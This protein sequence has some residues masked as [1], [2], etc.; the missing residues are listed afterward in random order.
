MKYQLLKR[1]AVAL[2]ITGA[3]ST[4]A[5]ATDPFSEAF[6]K[7]GQQLKDDLK[8]ETEAQLNQVK[9]DNEKYF[10]NTTKLIEENTNALKKKANISDVNDRFQATGEALEKVSEQIVD[11]ARSIEAVN[12]DV[13][14]NTQDIRVQKASIDAKAGK[15]YVAEALDKKAD[16]ATVD[17]E[18]AK[19]VSQEKLDQYHQSSVN[20]LAKHSDEIENIKQ[21]HNELADHVTSEINRVTDYVNNMSD[22]ID[23][24]T[25]EID[26]IKQAHNELADHVTSEINRVTD[27]VN[28]MSDDIDTNTA[29]IENI[30]QVHNELADHVTSEINR[31]TDYV[32]NMSDDVDANT[33]EIEKLKTTS[34]FLDA[35]KV[36]KNAKDIAENK[37]NIK[38]VAKTM[39]DGFEAISE[40]IKD[41]HRAIENV[42]KDVEK[43]TQDIRVQ[44][45]VIKTKASKEYVDGKLADKA[46]KAALANKAD[47][48]TV[49]NYHNSLVKAHESTQKAVGD[50]KTKIAANKAAVTKNEAAIKDNKE[51]VAKN[52]A[53][54]KANT[55]GIAQLKSAQQNVTA[56]K[57]KVDQNSARIDQLDNRVS[58]LDKEVKNGLASQAALSGLFQPYNVGKV[59]M[60]A[61]V[62]GY[63]SKTALAVGTGYRFN[64]NVAAKAGVAFSAN[65]G[66]ATYNAGVNFEW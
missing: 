27:Y 45:G 40:D 44:N 48:A 56:L 28:N 12:K 34:G 20:S 66:G 9:T 35:A 39:V 46:D 47:Q 41:N 1:T 16:K 32:N 29:E 21:V 55:A 24:N 19:K 15:K 65:G 50:N 11:N 42:N 3:V 37:E 61:A 57:T 4:G 30:K 23:T 49:E 38:T 8:K 13:E 14:K 10:T 59:N 54:I 64:E 31:V 2:F 52:E 62:G 22:D 60:S 63:K 53:A 58:D 26:N 36:E 17:A 43:N 51:A 33:A 7:A 6:T 5:F 18:L 25:A